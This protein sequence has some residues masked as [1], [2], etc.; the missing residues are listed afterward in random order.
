[1]DNKQNQPQH[2]GQQKQNQQ[3]G[4]QKPNQPHHGG[5]QKPNQPQP[6]RGGQSWNKPDQK[7]PQER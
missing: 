5:Q 7:N 6:E 4:Q 2:G 3:G 1:M